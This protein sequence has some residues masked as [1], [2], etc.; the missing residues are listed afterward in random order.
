MKNMT[1]SSR[2]VAV[3]GDLVGSR[4]QASRSDVQAA[5]AVAL[6]QAN[7]V[8]PAV[9]P[10]EDTIGDEFQGAYD[11]IEA[12]CLAALLVRLALPE[13]LDSRV[14]IGV[15]SI[16]IVGESRYGLTQDG[17]AWWSARE[18]IVDVKSGERRVPGLRTQVAGSQEGRGWMNAYLLNRDAI[19][20]RFD[21]RQRRL[22]LGVLTGLTRTQL[23]ETEGISASAVSQSLR[24]S[25]ASALIESVQVLRT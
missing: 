16:E 8:V 17:P 6:R 1:S 13:E 24:R 15:G 7:D 2:V 14:G 22:A 18:A 25:G 5:L 21:A 20:T 10:L 12:A 23:A 19:V 4:R 3:I 9:Q 11:T